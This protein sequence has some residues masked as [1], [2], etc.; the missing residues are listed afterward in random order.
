[1]KKIREL[2]KETGK[3]CGILLDTKGP[4]IRTGG[5]KDGKTSVK[6]KAGQTFTF[7]VNFIRGDETKVSIKYWNLP[8]L[9]KP[10]EKLYADYGLI[11]FTVQA[12]EDKAIIT[13]VD[14]DGT[15]GENKIVTVHGMRSNLDNPF[16]TYQDTVDI[17][18]A[19]THQLDFISASYVA[20]PEDILEIRRLPGVTESGIKILAKIESA[21]GI[22]NFD[23]ILA[24]AD[25]IQISRS[26]IANE[27]PVEKVAYVQKQIIRKCNLAGKPV[28][29]ANQIL[30]SMQFNP[31]PTRAECTDL[32]NAVF[33]GVDC[34]VL[35]NTTATAK[36]A[37]PVKSIKVACKQIYEVETKLIRYRDVYNVIREHMIYSDNIEMPWAE[38][39]TSS[40]VKT[41]WDLDATVIIVIS[42]N[43]NAA[44][45]VAKYRPHTPIICVTST[46]MTARQV[47]ISRGVIPLLLTTKVTGD[48]IP[49]IKQAISKTKEWGIAKPGEYAIAIYGEGTNVQESN[50][51][52]VFTVD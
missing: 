4:E 46:P 1:V 37:Y 25:G 16:L 43:G 24:V 34:V 15:L 30:N 23:A 42:E 10:G 5:F 39:V 51:Y 3:E 40:A 14:N 19:V 41:A 26:D 7:Y 18:F 29:V 28:M 45:Y 33:E 8:K 52:Q 2:S 48:P 47:L 17:D 36:C 27:I 31:R 21:E 49:V 11:S 13:T 20:R 6:L 22:Q 32:A 35:T 44:R 38:S 9:V 12:V 50:C